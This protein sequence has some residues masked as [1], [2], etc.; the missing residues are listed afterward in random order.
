M[1]NTIK[2][3]LSLLIIMM[4]IIGNLNLS[5]A[6]SKNDLD[7]NLNELSKI[8]LTIEKNST[9]KATKKQLRKTKKVYKKIKKLNINEKVKNIAVDSAYSVQ[10][11]CK[12][13]KKENKLTPTLKLKVDNCKVKIES[14]KI[15]NKGVKGKKVSE[16]IRFEA[17]RQLNYQ[18]INFNNKVLGV[19]TSNKEYDIDK[20]NATLSEIESQTSE[21]ENYFNGNTTN[22]DYDIINA[23]SDAQLAM[24]RF[25]AGKYTVG[26]YINKRT[27][28][29]DKINMYAPFDNFKS[30]S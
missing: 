24:L 23:I 5:F 1:K 9:K 11:L 21:I 10:E 6:D 20:L 26:Q 3:S 8:V 16:V 28:F 14:T 13:V 29:L 25:K 30:I 7:T 27:E 22:L 4:I 17:A 19:F 18:S 12:E 2:K 15:I